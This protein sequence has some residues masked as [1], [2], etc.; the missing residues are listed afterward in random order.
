MGGIGRSFF[1]GGDYFFSVHMEGPE[2]S[3]ICS[4]FCWPLEFLKLFFFFLEV[5]GGSEVILGC[6]EVF[7]I[8][9]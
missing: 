4:C 2:R 9:F 1:G 7:R 5:L 6:I 3:L 8:W